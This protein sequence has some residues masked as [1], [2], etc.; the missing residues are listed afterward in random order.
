MSEFRI[1]AILSQYDRTKHRG[2]IPRLISVL[3][4]SELLTNLI[5]VDNAREGDWTHR[6]SDDFVQA[7][8][9]NS[10]REFSAF[11]RGFEVAAREG[12]ECDAFLLVTDAFRAYGDDF[13]NLFDERVVECCSR[14]NACVGWMDSYMEECRIG[15]FAYD[16]WIRTSF[17]LVPPSLVELLRPMGADLSDLRLFTGDPE[18]PFSERADVSENLRSV[19]VEWLTN[20]EVET[21]RLEERWHSRFDLTEETLPF[22]QA[23]VTAIL[24]EHL[25]SAKLKSYAVPAYD[26][27]CI[28]RLGDCGTFEEF[29]ENGGDPRLEWLGWREHLPSLVDALLEDRRISL[30]DGAESA[31]GRF[32][33][34]AG[35]FEPGREDG[36]AVHLFAQKVLPLILQRDATVRLLVHSRG[37]SIEDIG[38]GYAK[39]VV[40]KDLGESGRLE[41]PAGCVA[42][43]APEHID[44]DG[45]SDFLAAT[46][47]ECRMVA[48][49]SIADQLDHP[50][51]AKAESY[52]AFAAECCKLLENGQS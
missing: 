50:N 26:L 42:S 23:K 33:A 8:G 38:L 45:V 18:A 46:G 40:V 43:V 32:L 36:R 14:L 6:I 4:R 41:L 35:L 12:L 30:D 21:S 19:L 31:D 7:G 9:D 34:F 25:M 10:L 49:A 2:S 51:L 44:T 22:F 29:L 48:D 5:V 15:R 52:V 16:T 13:L 27:R 11:D 37:L 39:N 28:R 3:D 20:R 47:G 17:V 24:L 1:T